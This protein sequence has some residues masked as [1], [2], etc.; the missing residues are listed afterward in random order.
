MNEI[1][2]QPFNM[3]ITNDLTQDQDNSEDSDREL[4]RDMLQGNMV[5]FE[6]LMHTQYRFLYHY[7]LKFTSDQEFVKDT[8]QDLFMH[9]WERRES[10]NADIPPKPYLMASLRRMMNRT[11]QKNT[12]VLD[13][14]AEP[15]NNP[16]LRIEFSVEKNYIRRESARVLSQR[17]KMLLDELPLRQKEVIYLKYYQELSRSQIAMVMDVA[18]QTVSNLLQMALKKLKKY[19]EDEF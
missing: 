3:P 1:L 19:W 8:V 6:R 18:P 2:S 12:T 15:S 4:W 7:G 14:S 5:A 13:P 11:Q 16:L 10:L 9:V 17:L